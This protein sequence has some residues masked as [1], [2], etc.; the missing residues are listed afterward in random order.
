MATREAPRRI[1]WDFG[2]IPLLPPQLSSRPE[3]PPTY[4]SPRLPIAMHSKLAVGRFDD[5]LEQEADHVADEVMRSP[6][7]EISINSMAPQLSCKCA[8]CANDELKTLRPKAMKPAQAAAEAPGAVQE[9]LL[10]PSKPLDDATRSFFETRFARDFSRVRVHTGAAAERS[11]RELNAYAYTVK[12]DVVFGAGQFAPKTYSGRRLIAHELAHVVQQSGGDAC[13]Q[14]SPD[15]RWA[16]DVHAARLRANIIAN[17][18]RKHGILSP[19]ARAKINAELQYFE[20]SAKDEYLRIVRPVLRAV[21]EI[22]IPEMNMVEKGVAQPPPAIPMQPSKPQ[23]CGTLPET[24]SGK[25]CKFFVY[26]STLPGA[27]GTLWEVAAFGDAAAR[28]ATYVIPSGENIEELL[29]N[30]L[31]TY[32]DKDCDCT[33][34]V[35]FW[36]H[37][38]KGNGAWISGSK[39]GKSQII[40]EDFNIPGIETFGDDRSLPGYQE[41]EAKLS[42]YQRRMV[43]LRRTICDSNSTIYYRSCLAFQGTEGQE[44]AKASASFW[45]CNVSGHTKSIGLS[46]PGK[47]TLA[48]C[49]EPDWPAA[50]GADEESKKDKEKLRA[51]KPK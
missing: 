43:L 33:D 2:Q 51:V 18:I 38:S 3:T 39:G 21:V 1:L 44:F 22:E 27:L 31:E 13:I 17:R 16:H 26:D 25:K 12:N 37:G 10:S 5:P 45:R 50:E 8:A 6:D 48:Q 30:L 35:Q 36:S 9:V 23:V 4:V 46:Q 20:G 15:E 19:E 42:R 41:W 24:S 47:H 40:A 28:P 11:T 34:E 7:L 49:Q 32:A 14:R 29:E